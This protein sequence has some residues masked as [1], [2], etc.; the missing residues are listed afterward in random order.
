M[1]LDLGAFLAVYG[2]IADGDGT[3]WS[4]GGP[5][6]DVGALTGL[7]GLGVPQGISNSHNKYESD[8]SPVRGDLY[9]YGN[10]YLNQMSQ[11]EALYAKGAADDSYD[12][13]LLTEF[14][15]ER[16]N[17]SLYNNP[18]FFNAPFS[19]VIV[20]PAAYTFIFRFMANKS[21]EYPEGYLNG[22]V[23]KSFYS[24][25]GE[26]G[27]FVYTPGYE[28]I[29]DNWY[30]RNVADPYSIPYFAVDL[31][32]AAMEYPQFLDIGG[33]LG[34]VD[35]FTGIDITNLTGG[36]YNLETLTEGNNLACFGF[37]IAVQF[38]P[39]LIEGLLTDTY[40]MGILGELLTNATYGLDCP[41]LDTIDTSQFAQFPGYADSYDGYSE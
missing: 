17:Q 1:G 19:G 31:N 27:S 35:T 18:Y 8:V 40:A 6:P 33:N 29:P 20:Q 38:L 36:I 10:D 32:E 13:A 9:E 34:E 25:T 41:Q 37:E 11:F 21:E 28:R 7:L 2:S 5:T 24:V 23:L 16:F 22:E 15:A 14:R 3:S 4:I 12:I 30:T 39:D 26:P